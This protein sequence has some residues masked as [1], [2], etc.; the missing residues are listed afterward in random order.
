MLLAIPVLLALIPWVG[1]AH[2]AETI[3]SP[4]GIHVGRTD[5]EVLPPEPPPPALRDQSK[6]PPPEAAPETLSQALPA[7][8]VSALEDGVSCTARLLYH[9]QT[10]GSAELVSL[11][12]E[13]A[14]PGE[15]REAFE[16]AILA[17]V[18][19]WEFAPA[20]QL[21][22]RIQPDESAHFEKRPIPKAAHA[23]VRFQVEDGQPVV[24]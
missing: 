8:P 7:Y 10:D 2:R 9:I 3:E 20:Y 24:Q 23:L 12:W 21:R 22:L 1:C 16:P 15:H 11:E 18:G 13:L 19:T 5:L 4:S 14:P 6:R 17:A